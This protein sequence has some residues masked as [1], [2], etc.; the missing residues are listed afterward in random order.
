MPARLAEEKLKTST[1]SNTAAA[2]TMASQAVGLNW[3]SF[4]S[5]HALYFLPLPHGHS[6]FRPT[7]ETRAIVQVP[8]FAVPR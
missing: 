4:R 2:P 6:W 1:A 5:Q 7:L 8:F 3:R